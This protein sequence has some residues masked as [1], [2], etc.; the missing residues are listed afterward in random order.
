VA[1]SLILRVLRVLFREDEAGWLA[2]A[3]NPFKPV[4]PLN[5][6]RLSRCSKCRA[7]PSGTR[8]V[9]ACVNMSVMRMM[10]GMILQ[11]RLKSE[12]PK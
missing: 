12:Q 10:S 2:G 8:S 1:V 7:L 5:G 3:K 4:I 9:G 11:L 6:S